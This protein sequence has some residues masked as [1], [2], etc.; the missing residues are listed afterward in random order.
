MDDVTGG[1]GARVFGPRFEPKEFRILTR[2]LQF[3]L[4]IKQTHSR[5]D[6]NSVQMHSVK[7][8]KLCKD[9]RV[10]LL[11]LISYLTLELLQIMVDYA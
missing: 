4:H 10:F 2:F 1:R 9:L 11:V 5:S 3:R 6:D 7:N 8:I